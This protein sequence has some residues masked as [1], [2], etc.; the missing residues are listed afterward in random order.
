MV[1]WQVETRSSQT[2]YFVIIFFEKLAMVL[3][4]HAQ[5]TSLT[6]QYP[7]EDIRTD[8]ITTHKRVWTITFDDNYKNS[9]YG[10]YVNDWGQHSG[11]INRS[12]WLT[13]MAMESLDRK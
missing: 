12:F 7:P 5:H 11:N 4:P 9:I 6:R 8:T 2:I 13:G 1:S 10:A 3:Q